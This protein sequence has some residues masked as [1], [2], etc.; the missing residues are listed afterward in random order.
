MPVYAYEGAVPDIA[1]DAF[2]APGAQVIGKVK[3]G[4]GSS[5]WYNCVLRGD[6]GTITVG[7]GA[8]IQDGT[9][10]H[11][12]GGK[13]DTMIGDRCLIGHTAIIHGCTLHDDAFVGLG[14]IVMDGCVIESDAMLAAGALLTPGKRIPSGQMWAGRPAKYVR[15]LTPQEIAG[16]R[17]G[18]KHYARLAKTHHDLPIVNP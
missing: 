2:I 16:N 11:I 13:F 15:D 7:A 18:P 9:V 8:N 10:V 6:V 17:E 3:I 4:A 14:A 5:V 1:Q 12:S